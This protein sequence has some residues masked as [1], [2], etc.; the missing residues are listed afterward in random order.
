M[1]LNWL[2][3]TTPEEVGIALFD[4]FSIGHITFGIGIFLLFSF[5][6]TIQT[7]RGITPYFSLLFVYICTFC[8]LL[9]WELLENTLFVSLGIKFEGRLDS[10]MNILTDLIMGAFGGLCTW[11]LCYQFVERDKNIN[12]YYA[13]GLTCFA[14][15]FIFFFILRFFTLN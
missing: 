4:F 1:L 3:G 5:F 15:W 11:F 8:V 9:I 2:I 6:Y 10:W 14:I 12:V 13:F 7:K